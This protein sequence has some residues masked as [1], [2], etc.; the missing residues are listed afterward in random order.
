MVIGGERAGVQSPFVRYAT[1]AGWTYLSPEDALRLRSGGVISPVLDVV[2]MDQLQRLNPG[3]VDHRRAEGTVKKLVRVRANI[4]GNLDAWGYLKGLKTVFVEEEKQE[5]NVRLLDPDHPEANRFHVTDEFTFSNGMPPDVRADIVFFV[6][7]IPV[8]F[9]ETKRATAMEGIAEAMDDIRY[10]HQKGPEL[11]ALGQIYALTHLLQF[12]YGATWNLSAK[13]LFNWRDE[14]VSTQNF[15]GLCKS[16]IAPR[17][18]LRTLT[19]FILFT[20]KDEELSKVILRPHQMRAV[21]CCI[22]RGRDRKRRRSLV[23]HTQGSGKTYTMI[24]VAKRLIDDPTFEHPTVLMLVDRNELEAQLYGNLEALGFGRVEVARTKA[25]LKKLLCSD[26]RGLIVSMIHKFDKVP[27]NLCARKNVF[28]LVDEAH[29]S[30]GGDLGNYLMGAL[31]NATY[32]GFTGTPIDRTAHGKGTF[33]VF[34]AEDEQGYLDKYSIRESIQDG[35]TVPLHYSLAPNELRVDRETLEREFLDLA[36]A[37]G[38]SDFE[39]LNR[40]L[41]RAVTLKN[42]L[43]NR[44]RVEKVAKF[45]A[46]HFIRNVEPMGYKAFLVGVDREACCFYKEALDRHLPP[47]YSRVVI[48]QAGKKD[49]EI[50]KKHYLSEDEEK[51]VRRAF[52]DAD[53]LP[54]IL[55]VTEK[56]LTG[57]DAPILYCMYL[58]KP[59]RDHVLLQAIARVNRPHEDT[60]GR[61]KRS[62]FV[63]D[64]V[65]LF[66]NLEKALAFDSKDVAGVIEGLDILRH[67][68]ADLMG[69]ART[70]YMPIMAGRSG[71]KQVEAVLEHFRDKKC[72]QE[73][74]AFFH[75]LQ[76]LYEILSPD[77][78]L[79]PYLPEYDDLVDMF[80]LVRNYYEREKSPDREFLRKTARLVQQHTKSGRIVEPE[81]A[82]ALNAE[83]L[84]KIAGKDQPETVKVFNLLKALHDL[85]SQRGR[86]EPYLISIGDRAEEIARAFEEHQMT[87]QQALEGLERLVADLKDAEKAR[88]ATGLSPEGFAAFYLLKQDGV[89]DAQR[90]AQQV[91]EAFGHYPHWQVSERQA[92]EVR[93]KLYKALM[94]AGV[95]KVA[96]GAT[97]LMKL[98]CR[99]AR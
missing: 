9:V 49:R 31:P 71:D 36:E 27:E 15:E 52:R 80:H 57:F 12:H 21:E 73:F 29:R 23:W 85:V 33:K 83:A 1:E 42:M 70:E 6:N 16:F 67:R 2:L 90:V 98:L 20:R 61:R 48:S 46:D 87:T 19:D 22:G 72:R 63:L 53:K 94:D 82:Y 4:E 65:G 62:G 68:F 39:E 30:T 86:N 32:I 96:D 26:R 91:S 58:D 77:V 88:E 5:R 89:A 18:V 25:H 17:R 10:Y 24:V 56:L 34:G 47:E 55:I 97:R 41:E 43:K 95:E 59:L 64:F 14:L 44:D 76:D 28:V 74:Y 54:K 66:D 37:E 40:V 8:L 69:T 75:E 13:A 38:V 7:G 60:E 81:K 3:V 93:V 78:F 92:Q 84:A 99:S 79:R 51:K 50:L 11:L 45:V 35:T